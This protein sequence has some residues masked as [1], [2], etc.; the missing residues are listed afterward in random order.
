MHS[1]VTSSAIQAQIKHRLVALSP[2]AFEFFAGDLLQHI[3]LESVNITRYV[4]DG[5]IDAHGELV[6][7]NNMVRLR[8][9]I[10]IK[11]L[12]KNVQR[13]DIDSFI[14]ALSGRFHHGIFVTTANFTEQARQKAYE[15]P[16][17]RVDTINGDQIAQI[18]GSHLLGLQTHQSEVVLDEDYFLG[19]EAL[20]DSQ[21]GMLREQQESY[22]TERSSSSEEAQSQDNEQQPLDLIS[23]KTLSYLLRTDMRTIRDNWISKGR[24][25][26]DVTQHIGNRPVYFFRRDRIEAIRSQFSLAQVPDSPAAWREAFLKFV[27][28]RN[29]SKSYKPV[30]LKAL[31]KTVN[32][33]GEASL[34][35]V[36]EEFRAFYLQRR[37]NKLVIELGPSILQDLDNTDLKAI[38]ALIL[39]FPL[40]RFKIQGFLNYDSESGIV[41]FEPQLWSELRWLDMFDL[42]ELADEQLRYYYARP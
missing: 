29:L 18:M 40:E 3:G 22:K 15:S 21:A 7:L 12:R 11:R 25:Q 39:Q 30:L 23:L 1:S 33:N 34:D 37:H 42:E 28:N 41:H 20:L 17:M 13:P 38:K 26:V 4:G 31:L 32:R 24:L 14:G 6:A 16:L 36:A 27:A 2:R 9:G 35:A 8:T 5:G 10:Q 19:F